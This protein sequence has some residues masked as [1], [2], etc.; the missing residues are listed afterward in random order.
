[1]VPIR[2]ELDSIYTGHVSRIVKRHN[3]RRVGILTKHLYAAVRVEFQAAHVLCE[4]IVTEVL[5][6]GD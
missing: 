3:C 6:T 4:I 2:K 1:M 5:A